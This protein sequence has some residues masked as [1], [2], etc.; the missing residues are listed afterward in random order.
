MTRRWVEQVCQGVASKDYLSEYLAIYFALL[1]SCRYM[2]DPRTVELVRAPYRTFEELLAGGRPSVDCDDWA[3]ALAAAFLSV[4][5]SAQYVTVAF[6]RRYYD[7]RLQYSHVFTRAFEPRSRQWVVFDPVAADKT[8]EMLS[9][10]QA[11]A[12]WPVA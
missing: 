10:V 11:S 8:Q 2:R 6:D 5:G 12:L 1:R 3:A 7:G 4:G 9:R